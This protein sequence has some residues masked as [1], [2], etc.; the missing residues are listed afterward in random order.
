MKKVNCMKLSV[1]NADHYIDARGRVRVRHE[2]D[3]SFTKFSFVSSFRDKYRLCWKEI[4][5]KL[6]SIISEGFDCQRCN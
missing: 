1:D 4:Y 5:E 3:K 6:R 2:I